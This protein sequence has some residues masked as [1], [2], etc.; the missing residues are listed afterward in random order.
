VL[1]IKCWDRHDVNIKSNLSYDNDFF[2]GSSGLE[3]YNPIKYYQIKDDDKKFWIELY[4]SEDPDRISVFPIDDAKNKI[5][6]D[7][8]YVECILCISSNGMLI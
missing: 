1:V 6:K 3:Q 5:M 2:L 7:D 4:S 8:L